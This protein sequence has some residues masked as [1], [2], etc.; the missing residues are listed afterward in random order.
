[1]LS[2]RDQGIQEIPEVIFSSHTERRICRVYPQPKHQLIIIHY[3]TETHKEHFL[4][5]FSLLSHRVLYTIKLPSIDYAEWFSLTDDGSYIGMKAGSS[6]F[7]ARLDPPFSSHRTT[8]IPQL[9]FI[10]SKSMDEH[11]AA[12]RL[13]QVDEHVDM[14][15]H[16]IVQS[17]WKIK[18]CLHSTNYL[19]EVEMDFTGK[20]WKLEQ[21]VDEQTLIVSTKLND[22]DLPF[23]SIRPHF[24]R[25]VLTS[26]PFGDAALIL[27][28]SN[29]HGTPYVQYVLGH[30]PDQQVSSFLAASTWSY[31]ISRGSISPQAP[32]FVSQFWD[33]S[34]ELYDKHTGLLLQTFSCPSQLQ[35]EMK[36]WHCRYDQEDTYYVLPS[37][38]MVWLLPSKINPF[39][40]C[41]NVCSGLFLDNKIAAASV[42]QFKCNTHVFYDNHM[43]G[44]V[45][46]MLYPD[47]EI[48]K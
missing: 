3:T 44:L 29:I 22:M 28:S 36:E 33:S 32:W 46:S 13:V 39:G 14:Y 20:L 24:P 4:V 9:C 16:R 21:K 35:F 25:K 37:G 15:D 42:L 11:C 23:L 30:G 47:Y 31:L 45:L 6:L 10:E 26:D 5:F 48:S 1:M 12:Y 19:K 2:V 43:F 40:V 17:Q 8:K 7:V 27:W 34:F 41:L 18:N 38:L